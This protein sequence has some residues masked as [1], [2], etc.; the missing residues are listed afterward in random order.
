MTLTLYCDITKNN[1]EI[2][3]L[4]KT[5]KDAKPPCSWNR[6]NSTTCR[7]DSWHTSCSDHN[8]VCHCGTEGNNGNDALN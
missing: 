1:F 2:T 3:K 8:R 5:I 4:L 6:C 7:S